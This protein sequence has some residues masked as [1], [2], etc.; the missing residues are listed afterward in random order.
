MSD[1]VAANPIRHII[2][3]LRLVAEKNVTRTE[4]EIVTGLSRATLMRLLRT[5]RLHCGVDI[6]FVRKNTRHD[7]YAGYYRINNY[8]VFSQKKLRGKI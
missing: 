5:M 1:R 2:Q 4:M 8:G 6:E 3:I 7:G